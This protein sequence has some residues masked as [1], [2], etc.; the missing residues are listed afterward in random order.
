MGWW[1][2]ENTQDV[3]GDGPLDA[4]TDAMVQIVSQYQTEFNRK[5][6]KSE[7]EA[8][9]T[10]VFGEE[11]PERGPIDGCVI[12]RVLVLGLEEGY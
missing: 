3:I 2:V 11:D 8:L 9:L 10:A 6:S 1:K 12:A 4:L 7:W 5:P